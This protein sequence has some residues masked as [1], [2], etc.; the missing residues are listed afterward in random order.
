MGPPSSSNPFLSEAEIR[1]WS[2]CVIGSAQGQIGAVERR[3]DFRSYLAR[4]PVIIALLSALAVVC[5]LAVTG[6]CTR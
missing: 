6:D 4:E 1:W 2:W 5:F 3:P